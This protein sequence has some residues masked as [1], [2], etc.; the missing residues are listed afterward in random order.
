MNISIKV[1][2][3]KDYQF[4]E[5]IKKKDVKELRFLTMNKLYP[6]DIK[7]LQ[8]LHDRSYIFYPEVLW[9]RLFESDSIELLIFLI[10]NNYKYNDLT[11][12]LLR[13]GNIKCV[14]Y[15]SN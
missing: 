15:L 2:T 11:S 12:K 9:N 4:E 14:K 1:V 13:S 6:R 5:A 8:Y 10:K 3:G 7:L